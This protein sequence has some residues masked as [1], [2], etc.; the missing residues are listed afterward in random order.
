MEPESFFAEAAH[1]ALQRF[2]FKEV[3]H[4]MQERPCDYLHF[5]ET[6]KY[7]LDFLLVEFSQVSETVQNYQDLIDH[8]ANTER[9]RHCCTEY[10]MRRI[11]N[12]LVNIK[13]TEFDQAAM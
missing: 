13:Q 7:F 4:Q 1:E 10:F 9:L 6:Y 2:N 8:D 5:V 3:P 12:S 11:H